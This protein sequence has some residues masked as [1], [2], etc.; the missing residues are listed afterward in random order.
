MIVEWECILECNL[1]CAY[2]TN[3][4]NGV[5]SPPIRY[6]RDR[7]KVFA[8]I[9]MLKDRYPD[10]ELFLFGGEPFVHPF[11][12]DIIGHLNK[13]DMKF[14]VQTNCTLP[15]RILAA[16]A[17]HPFT[18]Q[19][20]VHPNDIANWA[21]YR[22]GVTD[23]QHITRRIDV[24]FVGDNSF[25]AYA[26][27]LPYIKDKSMLYLA[28]VADFNTSEHIVNNQLF[29]FNKLKQSI[30]GRVYRFED[31]DRSFK[32]EDQMRGVWTPKGKPCMYKDAY[33]LYDPML[34]PYTCNYRQNNDICPNQ[35]CFL[36]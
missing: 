24:M 28:P 25:S 23:V 20:S 16:A 18:I 11:I 21:L 30:H 29:L 35:Q 4:H 19:V 14:V 9:D 5:V 7:S 27:L 15:Q 3:G 10:D 6:E 36:M 17:D 12:E 34:V 22:Q 13:V 2:C 26:D 33:V 32:W 31:G 8:F 1:R